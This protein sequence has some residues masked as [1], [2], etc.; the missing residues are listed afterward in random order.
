MNVIH[1]ETKSLAEHFLPEGET[2]RTFKA[3][4]EEFA[5]LERTATAKSKFYLLNQHPKFGAKEVTSITVKRV[6]ER[7]GNKLNEEEI[8][9]DYAIG[10]KLAEVHEIAERK[11]KQH[12]EPSITRKEI[13]EKHKGRTSKKILEDDGKADKNFLRQEI[14][15]IGQYLNQGE[16]PK[17]EYDRL[18]LKNSK[19]LFELLERDLPLLEQQKDY[20]NL[21]KVLNEMKKMYDNMQ[22]KQRYIKVHL[23]YNEK[24]FQGFKTTSDEITA[25]WVIDNMRNKDLK[26]LQNKL[27]EQAKD[28]LKTWKEEEKSN[29]SVC[30][31]TIIEKYKRI[32]LKSQISTFIEKQDIRK[33]EREGLHELL[34]SEEIRKHYEQIKHSM[35]GYKLRKLRKLLQ[36]DY[37]LKKQVLKQLLAISQKNKQLR[38]V[39]DKTNSIEERIAHLNNKRVNVLKP[40]DD[41]LALKQ[42]TIQ[43]YENRLPSSMR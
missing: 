11:D 12:G 10:E 41:D 15:R 19:K 36:H 20:E 18:M 34:G 33:L 13:E 40:M 23:R 5:A 14:E 30:E 27:I 8:D 29:E 38:L 1:P 43:E 37:N 35:T 9:I 24:E 16:I 17:G 2:E 6:L 26:N 42:A 28:K 3:G 31:K 32:M 39:D 7:D 25:K 22:T 21:R 4:S